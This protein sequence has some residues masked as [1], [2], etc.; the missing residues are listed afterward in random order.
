MESVTG[1]YLLRESTQQELLVGA[2]IIYPVT[3]EKHRT[4][5]LRAQTT[6]RGF[7]KLA[8]A[9]AVHFILTIPCVVTRMASEKKN[10]LLPHAKWGMT[11]VKYI[12]RANTGGG[13]IVIRLV[14]RW[15]TVVSSL[16]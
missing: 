14:D 3:S 15:Y 8:C 1:R 9:A 7:C 2:S 6:T 10:L 11:I 12:E 16:T 4:S 13:D 5:H